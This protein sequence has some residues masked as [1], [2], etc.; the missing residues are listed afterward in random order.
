[1]VGGARPARSMTRAIVMRMAF[2]YAQNVKNSA[3]PAIRY[4]GKV[5]KK[6]I[7]Y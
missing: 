2:Q 4:K 6:T 7:L 5:S 1:M 3:I